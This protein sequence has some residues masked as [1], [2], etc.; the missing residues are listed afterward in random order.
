MSD[1]IIPF[2]TGKDEEPEHCCSSCDLANE[3]LF[4]VL[5]TLGNGTTEDL[6]GV[7]R[8]L[9]DE[10]G[11]LALSDYLKSE[12]EYAVKLIDQLEYGID[13]EN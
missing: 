4:Y 5:D 9:V 2:Y 10:A 12:V 8:A 6:F 3:Y 11:K 1:N 13:E 7:L